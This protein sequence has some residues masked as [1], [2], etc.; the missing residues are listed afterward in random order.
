M[1]THTNILWGSTS[2]KPRGKSLTEF[3]V[4]SNLNILNHGNEP[5]FVVCN[6][7]EIIDLA[8]EKNKVPS[9]LLVVVLQPI[10]ITSKYT[11]SHAPNPGV[12]LK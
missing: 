4:S 7:K 3:L 10:H 1:P 11:D 12:Q 8:V 9:T 2:T 5:T 6:K